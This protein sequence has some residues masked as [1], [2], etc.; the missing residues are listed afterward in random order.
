MNLMS[1]SFVGIA[2][3][4]K[5][6]DAEASSAKMRSVFILSLELRFSRKFSVIQ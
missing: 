5:R 2:A 6:V 4:D 1:S 3:A